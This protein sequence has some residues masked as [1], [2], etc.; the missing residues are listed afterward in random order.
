C[1][2]HQPTILRGVTVNTF[3]TCRL[4]IGSTLLGSL[5]GLATGCSHVQQQDIEYTPPAQRVHAVTEAPWPQNH[6]LVLAY[7]DV[8]DTDPDQTFVSVLTEHLRQQ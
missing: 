1:F 2:E 3:L 8:E 5:L 4:A 6:F 7:H